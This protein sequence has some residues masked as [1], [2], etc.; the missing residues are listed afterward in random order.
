MRR[1]LQPP[2]A[3]LALVSLMSLVDAAPLNLMSAPNRLRVGTSE[4]IFVECQDCLGGSLSVT[5]SVSSYP[6][7]IRLLAET[8]VILSSTNNFQ[9][10]GQILVKLPPVKQYVYL[11][12]KFPNQVL[13]KVVLVSFQSGF[14]FIQTDNTLYTPKSTV[15]YRLFGVTPRMEPLDRSSNAHTDNTVSIQ[16]MTPEGITFARNRISLRAGIYSDNYKL[17]E[18]V[19]PGLWKIVASFM[20]DPEKRFSANFEVKEHVSSSFEVKLSSPSPF[21]HVDS[22]SLEIDIKATY[23]FGQEVDGMAYVVFGVMDNG[24]QKSLNHSLSRVPIEHGTGK[25]ELKRDHITMAFHD[26]RQLVGMSIFV[27]VSVLT[28]GGSEMVEAELKDIHIVTSPYSITFRRTPKYFKPGMVF[29]MTVEVLN[30]DKSPAQDIPVVVNPGAIRAI[31]VNGVVRL[32]INAPSGDQNLQISA[33]TDDPKILPDRQA[34]ASMVAKPY[35][36]NSKSYIYIGV[37][38]AEVKLGDNLKVSIILNKQTSQDITYL[39]TSRGQLAK[40]GRQK[41]RGQTLIAFLVPISQELLPSFRIIAFYHTDENEVVSDSVWLDVKDSC[42]GSLRLEPLRPANSFEPRQLFSMR[43]TGDPGSVVGLVAV[44]RDTYVQSNKHRL[45]QKKVW[46]KVEKYDTSCSPGGGK[47]GLS[48]FFDAG[49]LFESS[50]VSGTY[51]HGE[52]IS[53]ES[54]LVVEKQK[55]LS[56]FFRW[57]K[58]YSLCSC[59]PDENDDSYMDSSEI[60]SR[61]IFPKSFLWTEVILP[62]CP[63]ESP[64]CD[65]TSSVRNVF[66]QDFITTWQIIAI[67]L[68]STSGICVGE[69]LEI[70]VRKDFFID[71]RLPFSAV[72][73]EQLE[74]KAILHNYRR[75][76]LTV[77]IELIKEKDVCSAASKHG[78]YRQEVRVEPMTTRSVPFIIIPMKE[79]LVTLEVKATVKDGYL[80]DGVRKD[81]WVFV[82]VLKSVQTVTVNPSHK[83]ENGVQVV[84]LNSNISGSNLV[85]NSP[86]STYIFVSAKLPKEN[87]TIEIPMTFL[88]PW[89]HPPHESAEMVMIHMTLPVIGTT[90]LDKTNQWGAVGPQKRVTALQNIKTGYNNVLVHLKND[91]SFTASNNA[92]STW[93]TAYVVKVLLMANELV[94]IRE[95]HICDAVNFLILNAQLPDGSFREI[96]NIYNRE[97]MGIVAHSDSLTA[98]CLIAMQESRPVCSNTIHRLPSSINKAVV[99]LENQLPGL[100]SPSAV[101]MTSYALANEGK[102][103][104]QIL[105]NVAS[106]E[107]SHWPVPGNSL[108]TLEATA[109]A[110]LALVQA[111]AFDDARPVVRWFNHQRLGGLGREYTQATMMM[112]QAL[113]EYW[114][115]VPEQD[116]YLDVFLPDRSKPEKYY[117]NHKNIYVTRTFQDKLNKDVTVRV[118]GSGEATIKMTSSY[119]AP[120]QDTKGDCQKFQMSVTLIPGNS[121]YKDSNR[122]ATMS[123]LDIGL[124]TGFAVNTDDLRAISIGQDAIIDRF[125]MNTALSDRGSLIIYLERVSHTRPK[126]ISFRLHQVQQV[127]ILQPATVSVYEYYEDTPCVMFYHPQ[128]AEGQLLQLC[129]ACSTQKKSKISSNERITKLCE[130]TDGNLMYGTRSPSPLVITG[131]NDVGT[132]GKLRNFISYPHCRKA[133]SLQNGSTYLV[134]GSSSD[135]NHGDGQETYQYNLGEHTW[136]EY[137]PTVEECQLDEHRLTCLGLE[138]M[139]EEFV[140]FGCLE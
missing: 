116:L 84:V 128:V 81:M 127:S 87:I 131:S 89:T 44:D 124:L 106:P 8:Q 103:N 48:V 53:T 140:K 115:N 41:T 32:P 55:T 104:R 62:A 135:I 29:D 100:T 6:T 21:F 137:W 82:I 134:M 113:G 37:D 85:P 138:D 1:T 57:S 9:S 68:S 12:A 93:L 51:T 54:F 42:M 23:V 98:F 60:I 130:R 119:Y 14:I 99:Y 111:K 58:L 4:N 66:L 30:P 19:S 43:V 71:L 69:P 126:I 31:T 112:Y 133:L 129:A 102:L 72:L 35:S 108:F 97:M 132:T 76:I 73:R 26:L 22:E 49:L 64:S 47:D 74:V 25:A 11:E 80:S 92:G 136:I 5:I 83:G 7:K 24:Q 79:G 110:L 16:I 20:N 13:E 121:L 95:E 109:Y 125:D 34:S 107:L 88:N 78:K 17:D 67:S 77:R 114:T 27:S 28:V 2:L 122:D 33:K 86:S 120:S 96:G 40:F 117:I 38:T 63:A 101:A 90:Y 50:E 45:T 56:S 123:I 46:D 139:M 52:Y 105:Y 18:F 61:S 39:I 118:S 3:F 36:T 70:N 91:G 94:A 15:Y 75:E 65:S 10:F 59:I